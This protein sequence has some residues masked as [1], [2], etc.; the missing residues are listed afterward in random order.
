MIYIR[1]ALIVRKS[2]KL[3]HEKERLFARE[4]NNDIPE[5][6]HNLRIMTVVDDQK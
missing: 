3:V 6:K 5:R 4:K 1:K 2:M